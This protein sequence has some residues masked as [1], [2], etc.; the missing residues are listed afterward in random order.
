MSLTAACTQRESGKPLVEQGRFAEVA[1]T[2]VQNGCRQDINQELVGAC[3]WNEGMKE[4]SAYSSFAPTCRPFRAAPPAR[5]QSIETPGQFESHAEARKRSGQ[6][7]CVRSDSRMSSIIGSSSRR[8]SSSWHCE[9]KNKTDQ[10][11]T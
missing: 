6:D 11:E 1:E 8:F 10:S 3:D 7:V 2:A 9:N 4:E 5:L